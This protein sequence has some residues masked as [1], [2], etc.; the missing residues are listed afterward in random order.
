MPAVGSFA[1]C[2]HELLGFPHVTLLGLLRKHMALI[3]TYLGTCRQ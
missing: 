3:G 1:Y 2:E